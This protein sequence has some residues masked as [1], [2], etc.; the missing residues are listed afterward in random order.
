MPLHQ[1]NDQINPH[2]QK[3]RRKLAQSLIT[4]YLEKQKE[5][6]F[7]EEALS[8]LSQ[9]ILLVN[10][11]T[12]P[13]KKTDSFFKTDGFDLSKIK[14]D[15]ARYQQV[16][17]AKE[18]WAVAISCL[19]TIAYSLAAASLPSFIL[20][21]GIFIAQAHIGTIAA[22]LFFIILGSLSLLCTQ[23]YIWLHHQDKKPSRY[24]LLNQRFCQFYNQDF[25]QEIVPK[26]YEEAD[27]NNVLNGEAPLSTIC[28]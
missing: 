16:A 14:H 27:I 19:K 18:K 6:G 24:K 21:A 25:K 28:Q 3:R 22:V 12:T 23:A 13:L 11:G 20:A 2:V 5:S 7:N 8:A 15:Q 10:N 1:S 9:Y 26:L 17:E 4:L